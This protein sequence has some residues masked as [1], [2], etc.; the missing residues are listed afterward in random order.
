MKNP[1]QP[2]YLDYVNLTIEG[3]EDLSVRPWKGPSP[4]KVIPIE[5]SSASVHGENF[6][7][8]IANEEDTS[9]RPWRQ[10]TATPAGNGAMPLP[11]AS[12]GEQ[13][14]SGHGDASENPD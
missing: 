1:N 7:S 3:N 9:V 12:Q 2:D 13:A 8:L 14:V 4:S 6:H 10:S 5:E 11:T